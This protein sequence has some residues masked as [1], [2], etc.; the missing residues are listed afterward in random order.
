MIREKSNFQI[1]VC[2]TI[3]TI[4]IIT[5]CAN[6]MITGKQ[7]RIKCGIVLNVEAAEPTIVDFVL[8]CFD[9]KIWR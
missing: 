7:N 2:D 4:I 8:D 6:N 1:V 5:S 9:I 3:I